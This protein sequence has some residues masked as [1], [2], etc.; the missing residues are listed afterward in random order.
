LS[1]PLQLV[2]AERDEFEIEI[3]ASANPVSFHFDETKPARS[4]SIA[5]VAFQKK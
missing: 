3:A 1:G 2:N 4:V 5:D